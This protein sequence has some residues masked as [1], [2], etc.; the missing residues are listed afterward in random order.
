MKR[1]VILVLLLFCASYPQTG[2]EIRLP[3]VDEIVDINLGEESVFACVQ[4]RDAETD[5]INGIIALDV[6]TGE[7]LWFHGTDYDDYL[8]TVPHDVQFHDNKVY[9]A[10]SHYGILCLDARSGTEIFI[11][12]I[13]GDIIA[14]IIID[15][16]VLYAASTSELV[17]MDANTGEDAWNLIMEPCEDGIPRPVSHIYLH[18]D[19]LLAGSIYPSLRCV[20]SRTGRLLW[21]TTEDPWVCESS[22]W[23][24]VIEVFD[25]TAYIKTSSPEL[26]IMDLNSQDV[27]AFHKNCIYLAGDEEWIY[28]YYPEDVE[29]LICLVEP[30][31]G[32]I[33]DRVVPDIQIDIKE[34]EFTQDLLCFGSWDG[35]FWIHPRNNFNGLSNCTFVRQ[36]SEEDIEVEISGERIFAVSEDGIVFSI[37]TQLED[38]WI[39]E[40]GLEFEDPLL[41]D[42]ARCI[43]PT[44]NSLYVIDY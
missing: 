10:V 15:N 19:M 34:M 5:R 35:Q 31:S 30:E 33:T 16:D 17:A 9:A 29:S 32:L 6:E 14:P 27:I 25:N 18:D 20:D 36:I 1:S 40:T 23:V 44:A 42:G 3:G 21:I 4:Y 39:I 13:T 26:T 41:V 2:T 24:E 7:E 38:E 43:I 11:R 12:E 22:S 37:S 28:L 8:S